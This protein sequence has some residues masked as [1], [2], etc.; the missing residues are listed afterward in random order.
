MRNLANILRKADI[1]PRDRILTLVR[2]DVEKDKTGKRILTESEIYSMI[3]GWRPKNSHEVNEYNTYLELSKLEASMRL[4]AQ[5]FTCHSENILLR[6]HIILNHIKYNDTVSKKPRNIISDKYI[7]HEEI[8]DFVVKNTYL[9]YTTLLHTLTFNNLPK[10]IQ[11]DLVI[12]DEY[13]AHN[14]KYLEDEVFLYELFNG[15]ETLSAENKDTLIH[16]IYS[17]IYHEGF[18]KIKNGSE[19]DGLLLL[20]FFAELPMEAVLMKWTEYAHI[21]VAGKD[22]DYVLDKLEEYAKGKNQTMEMIIK[23]TLSRWIDG[24]LFTKEYIPIFFSNEHNTWNGNTK[25]THRDIFTLW[26]QELQETKMFMDTLVSKGDLITEDF[27]KDLFGVTERIRIVTGESVHGSKVD[28]DFVKEFKEQVTIVLPLAGMYLF[29]EK[30][31]KPLDNLETLRCF[32]ELSK[33]FSGLF[34]VDMTD[35]Y[36]GFLDSFEQEIKLLNQSISMSLDAMNNFL[37]TK[38][39]KKYL[40]GIKDVNF[41]FDINNKSEKVVN[42]IIERYEEEIRRSGL[43]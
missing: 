37:C 23:E 34:D 4:D 19:K 36:K 6:S 42:T 8:I 15:S 32:H 28:I 5:M 17:C 11:D 33:T 9:D 41:L 38:N 1:T 16:R 35:K 27:D 20:H 43:V 31:N 14:T 7:P 39:N 18:R 10:D 29:I 22:T 24:G 2:N 21:D 40:L 3:Q 12:L 25:L 30:Y 26:Y 13:V